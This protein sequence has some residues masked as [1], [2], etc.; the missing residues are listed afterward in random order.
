M[1]RSLWKKNARYKES[2]MMMAMSCKEANIEDFISNVDDLQHFL[3]NL[4]PH[5]LSF[6]ESAYETSKFLKDVK[7]I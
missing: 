1:H 5:A 3:Y 2:L 7:Q 6:L 4:T